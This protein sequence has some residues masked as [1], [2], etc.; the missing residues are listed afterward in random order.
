MLI[1]PTPVPAQRPQAVTKLKYSHEAMIDLILQ[2]PTVTHREL[3]ELFGFTPSWI[4]RVIV[5]DSF[6]ARLAERK[7]MLVDPNITQSLNERLGSV[8]L[9]SL[10]IISKKLSSEQSADY[11]IEALGLAA[12]GMGIDKRSMRTA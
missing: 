6:Q 11:A 3:A 4:A 9:Q 1:Q 5:A 10:D 2:D 12:K 8:A 7:G